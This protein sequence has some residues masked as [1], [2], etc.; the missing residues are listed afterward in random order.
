MFFIASNLAS[1]HAN[2]LDAVRLITCVL[3]ALLSDADVR[4]QLD[5]AERGGR[6]KRA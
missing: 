5:D 2:S 4:R 1:V 6:P 3:A